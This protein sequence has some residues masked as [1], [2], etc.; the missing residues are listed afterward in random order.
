MR[1]RVGDNSAESPGCFA[2]SALEV[3]G[4]FSAEGSWIRLVSSGFSVWKR[5]KSAF[6][7]KAGIQAGGREPANERS[8][9]LIMRGEVVS[10]LCAL[11]WAP[12]FA[13]EAVEKPARVEKAR[14]R[15][16]SCPSG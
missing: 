1:R 6:P 14:P 10:A 3:L 16:S 15:K 2:V 9:E 12:D 11:D 5:T 4:K 8:F 7:A 13:G